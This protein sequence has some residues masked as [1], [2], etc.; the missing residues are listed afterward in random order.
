MNKILHP[1]H[2][3]ITASLFGCAIGDAMGG[4]LESMTSAEIFKKFGIV[5][6]F[7]EYDEKHRPSFH[8][9]FSS[10]A[11]TYTD[12]T[13]L[14]KLLALGAIASGG[15]PSSGDLNR[16][17]C[18]TYYTTDSPI[19]R[20]FLEEYVMKALYR[21][22][23]EAFGGK[24]TN[25]AI[26]S[27]APIGVL[28]P[29]DP[30]RAFDT[31]FH[32]LTM[33]TGSARIS[34]A[35]AAACISASMVSINASEAIAAGISSA[36]NRIKR[37]EGNYWYRSTL[38]KAVGGWT[39][40]LAKRAV[41][42]ATEFH[43]PLSSTFKKQLY[44]EISQ[45]F[46]A[47]GDETLAVALAMFVAA[48]GNFRNTIIGAANYGKDCDSYAAVAGALA[49]A[50][51]GVK[52]IPEKWLLKIEECDTAP[53]IS[54]IADALCATIMHR[55]NREKISVSSFVPPAINK[56][57]QKGLLA[58][59]K[60]GNEEEV[61]KILLAGADLNEKG[62]HGRTALHFAC[63]AGSL[64]LVRA[65]LLFGDDLNKKDLN[66]TT[67]LHFAAWENHFDIVDLLLN[68]GIS[69]EET[70]GQ[71]WMAIHD[72]V[73]KELYDIPLRILKKTRGLQ[74]EDTLKAELEILHGEA[75]FIRLLAVLSE[76]HIPLDSKGICGHGFFHDAKTRNY[77]RALQYLHTKGIENED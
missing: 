21:N 25:G 44:K 37:M 18:S 11:G 51:T 35:T 54:E 39:L 45:P 69:A 29:G 70:E 61:L 41:S 15:M 31:A 77:Q 74:D 58:A 2:D 40:E 64:P 76:Y 5:D 12:D 43:D 27:I 49:G 33:A 4:P 38:Y 13:R 42:L 24:I 60:S 8:G 73:R 20:G 1:L 53:K 59:V 36:E 65:L 19:L 30:Y 48:D 7:L 72:A 66:N 62:E 46:F 14:A 34:A 9:A 71:G 6:N 75:R 63:A 10:Q 57:P 23:K 55:I 28:F 47:D 68:Y 52:S 17:L 32:T 22:E 26:M 67:A 16:V 56:T 50:F 3:K